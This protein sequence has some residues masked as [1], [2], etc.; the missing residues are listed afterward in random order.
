MALEL[1]ATDECFLMAPRRIGN[2]SFVFGWISKLQSG[3]SLR[4]EDSLRRSTR[5][6]LLAITVASFAD[7]LK[8][9]PE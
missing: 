5:H 6:E 4:L 9:A 2:R 8:L 7:D 1:R 3:R